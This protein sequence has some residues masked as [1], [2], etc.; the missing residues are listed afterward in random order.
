MAVN[1][2]DKV[3]VSNIFLPK[4]HRQYKPDQWYEGEFIG[5]CHPLSVFKY[6][7]RVNGVTS[8]WKNMKL[9]EK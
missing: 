2:G 7:V 1:K 3:L 8:D 9:I 6:R 5:E 4:Y